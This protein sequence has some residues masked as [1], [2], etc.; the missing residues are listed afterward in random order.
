MIS[1]A[2]KI[3]QVWKNNASQAEDVLG[4]GVDVSASQSSVCS[5]LVHQM[6]EFCMNKSFIIG[7]WIN[8]CLSYAF[9]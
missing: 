6:D 4:K 3:E 8:Q 9:F 1:I 7:F 5:V 2:S